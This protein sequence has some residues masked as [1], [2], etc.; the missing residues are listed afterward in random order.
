[1]ENL[2]YFFLRANES[3]PLVISLDRCTDIFCSFAVV[4]S[5]CT[6]EL[7]WVTQVFCD[8]L[9]E[10]FVGVLGP[11]PVSHILYCCPN[12]FP[13]VIQLSQVGE[14]ATLVV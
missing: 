9:S 13:F 7:T 14:A 12:P 10:L 6:P 8:S 11:S 2:H 5:E 3:L 4:S 1:M